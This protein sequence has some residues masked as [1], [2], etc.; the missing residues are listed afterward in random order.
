[1]VQVMAWRQIGAKPLPEPVMTQFMDAYVCLSDTLSYFRS[2]LY[3][4]I[5]YECPSP[6]SHSLLMPGFL[7]VSVWRISF[8]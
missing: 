3:K 6:K 1:M 4:I 2:Q 5:C 8:K 7:H